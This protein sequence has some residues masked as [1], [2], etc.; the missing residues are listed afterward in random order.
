[1]NNVWKIL[2]RSIKSA[3]KQFKGSFA[4]SASIIFGVLTVVIELYILS[5]ISVLPGILLILPFTFIN[6]VFMNFWFDITS[7]W[8]F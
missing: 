5:N 7:D 8:G 3:T 2:G 6:L 1:M 4:I